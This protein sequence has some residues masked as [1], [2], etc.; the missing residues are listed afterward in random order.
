MQAGGPAWHCTQMHSCHHTRKRDETDLTH[1]AASSQTLCSRLPYPACGA[2]SSHAP[3]AETVQHHCPQPN[4]LRYCAKPSQRNQTM[5]QLEP[6]NSLPPIV[7]SRCE[8]RSPRPAMRCFPCAPDLQEH[9]LATAKHCKELQR[10][11]KKLWLLSKR[12]RMKRL[13]H[14]LKWSAYG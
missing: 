13:E 5:R 7:L 2:V 9:L 11:A 14:W 1:S 4:S 3:T 12:Q 6:S 8:R 10:T